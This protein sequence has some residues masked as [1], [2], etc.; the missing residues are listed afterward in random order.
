M[1][2]GRRGAY[3]VCSFRFPILREVVM[4]RTLAGIGGLA[5][6][7]GVIAA[8]VLPGPGTGAGVL[9]GLIGYMT[10]A[11]GMALCNG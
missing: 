7:G 4:C 8:I 11:F 5:S 6:M 10:G 1:T 2:G 9:L 3:D